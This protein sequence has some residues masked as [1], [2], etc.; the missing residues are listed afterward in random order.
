VRFPLEV[1]M[2]AD[3]ILFLIWNCSKIAVNESI[4]NLYAFDVLIGRVSS[5]CQ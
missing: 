2:S 4:W 1:M 5:M 3:G